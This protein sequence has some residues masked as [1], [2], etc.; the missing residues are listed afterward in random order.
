MYEC[1]WR[2]FQTWCEKVGRPSM[3]ASADTAA[4]YATWLLIE[5]GCKVSTAKQHVAAIAWFHRQS[6]HASPITRDVRSVLTG[7][8]RQRKEQP[9][10]RLALDRGDLARVSRVCDASGAE[11]A[12]DRAVIVLGFATALRRSE[13][14]AL[15]LSDV[16]FEREGLT[17]MVRSSKTDQEGKGRAI[18]VWRGKRP[19]TDPVRVIHEWIAKR[20]RWEGP[21]F[22]RV[23]AGEII[24]TPISGN[25]INRIVVEAVTR[26]GLDPA[27]YGAHSL[28]AGAITAAAEIGRSD[29]EIMGLS[30]H[31]SADIMRQYI[32]RAR[33]FSGRNPLE[34]V[35]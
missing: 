27:R 32:R 5:R 21:L 14:A 28:R 15:Q 3:P 16:H 26:A 35:L 8:K 34:G 24:R 30:G 20:G 29:R 33:V 23:F 11:G 6:G 18:G 2:Q 4:L 13:L 12:R 31:E 1:D 9:Q 7:V 25:T 10:G 17:V 22:C 19:V